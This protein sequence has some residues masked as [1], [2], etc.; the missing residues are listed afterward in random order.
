MGRAQDLLAEFRKLEPVASESAV[1]DDGHD[2]RALPDGRLVPLDYD[3]QEP[4]PEIG[5][6]S[7]ATYD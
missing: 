1:V 4:G 6:G 5:R 2:V 7:P 3:E